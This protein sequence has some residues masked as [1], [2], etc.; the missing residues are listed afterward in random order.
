VAQLN[1]VDGL[2]DA[3]VAQ[4][5]AVVGASRNLRAE[6]GLS[7]AERLPLLATGDGAFIDAAAPLIKMLA[8]VSEVKALD[9]AAFGDATQAAP[10]AVAGPVRLAL[11]VEVNVAVE[12]ARLAKE[13][14]RLDGEVSKAEAKLA[15]QGFVARAP[16]AVVEQEQRRLA[17]FRQA[18]RR[19][20]DQS[21]R[22][23]RPADRHPQ[24]PNSSA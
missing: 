10:V 23:G 17:D 12:Q 3:W 1:K 19:L 15:N 7:P 8:K 13:I 24:A 16:A 11:K 5:K 9:D 6:M 22:L 4:L 21:D 20:R 18:L 2:A 14:A